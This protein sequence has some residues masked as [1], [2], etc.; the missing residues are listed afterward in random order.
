MKIKLKDLDDYMLDE[1]YSKQASLLNDGVLKAASDEYLLYVFDSN[2]TFNKFNENLL[3]IESL[4]EKILGQKY[5]L[6]STNNI[7]W[8]I[9]KKEF[10]SK[11]RDYLYVVEDFDLTK[12]T[13]ADKKTELVD[14]FENIIE[15][16]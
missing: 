13:T 11:E 2:G 8:E 5:K 9:I 15:Y 3:E 10:N 7:S 4:V 14:C 16:E 6:I 1:K 12:L